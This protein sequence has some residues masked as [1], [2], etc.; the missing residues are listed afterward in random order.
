[1]LASDLYG[2][3]DAANDLLFDALLLPEVIDDAFHSRGI[4]KLPEY[5]KS[6]AASLHKF[7]YDKKV[8]Y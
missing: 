1:V 2:I 7:Y 8:G 4:Q 5:L 3:D 6:L